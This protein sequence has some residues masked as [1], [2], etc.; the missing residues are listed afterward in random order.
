MNTQH[1]LLQRWVDALNAEPLNLETAQESARALS[2]SLDTSTQMRNLVAAL[3][4][5]VDDPL[6]CTSC[7]ERLPEF[8]H[9]AANSRDQNPSSDERFADVRKHLQFC[10][11]CTAAFADVAEMARLSLANAI[12][13]ADSY[14]EFDLTF[15]TSLASTEFKTGMV[16]ADAKTDIKGSVKVLIENALQ[17]GREWI[18]DAAGGIALVFGPGLQTQAADGWTVKSSGT[19]SLLAQVVLSDDDV[20]GWEIEGSVFADPE[21]ESLCQLEVSIYSL[22]NPDQDLSGLPLTIGYGETEIHVE[23]GQGGIAEFGDIPKEQL[24]KLGVYINLP[25]G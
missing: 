10:P 25:S 13:R 11:Y 19:N 8:V 1:E 22:D 18:D 3:L 12:P 9:A 24:P 5:D 6:D 15:L 14:P 16:H 2:Q 7:Q 17:S 20:E 4:G 21:D 23:T